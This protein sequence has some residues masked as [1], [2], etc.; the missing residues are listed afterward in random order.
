MGVRRLIGQKTYWHLL[1]Q[2]RM[3][4]AYEVAS[5]RLLYYPERGFAVRTPASAW[6]SKY[7]RGSA[8][9]IDDWDK[10]VDPRQTTYTSYVELL[11]DREVF[12]SALE[13]ANDDPQPSREWLTHVADVMSVLRYPYHGF[14]M[15]TAYV[16]SMAPSGR[17]VIAAAF[18][19]ADEQRCVHRFAQRLAALQQ[20]LEVPNRGRELWEDAPAWQPLRELVENLLVAYDWGE[21]FAALNLAIKPALDRLV[22]DELAAAAR[23]KGDSITSGMLRSLA[24]DAAWHQA[25]SHALAELAVCERPENEAVIE[26]WVH[27]WRSRAHAA[28]DAA[29]PALMG[30]VS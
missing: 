30:G 9:H 21:S 6:Y 24:E 19:A 1:D 29:A 12:V 20:R 14:A 15:A 28:I 10:F 22:L 2:Q 7:Q 23:S 18:Q 16:G 13:R 11:R 5:S 3:P 8:L 17:I 27:P 25:W 26:A 4:S